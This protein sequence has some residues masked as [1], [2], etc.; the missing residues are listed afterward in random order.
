MRKWII[1]GIV[2]LLGCCPVTAKAASG[3]IEIQLQGD[4]ECEISYCKI[5]DMINGLWELNDTYKE[6]MVDLNAVDDAE[7]LQEAAKDM[8][9]YI[10]ERQLYM[11]E[12]MGTKSILLENLEEGLYLIVSRGN[13]GGKM[14][15]TLVSVPG[16]MEEERIYNVTVIPKFLE[17]KTAPV[18]GWDSWEI[19]YAGIAGISLV[20]IIRLFYYK[21]RYYSK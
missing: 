21:R 19:G 9:S 1:F 13:N 6:S 4:K 14:L 11:E 15:P 10:D 2:F 18:T 8:L 3:S 7:E 5:A 20:A 16:W 12:E 17:R